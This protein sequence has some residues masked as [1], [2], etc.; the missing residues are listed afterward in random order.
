M[1][2]VQD[3]GVTLLNL[4]ADPATHALAVSDG[5]TGSN[6]GP[7]QSR[8]DGNH[9]HALVAV[10]NADGKTPVVLYADSLQELLI[11]ST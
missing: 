3:D 6:N 5:T 7:T 11:K 1:L 8:H 10:S 4:K 2:A 9:T